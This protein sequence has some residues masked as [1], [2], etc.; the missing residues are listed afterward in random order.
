MMIARSC[1]RRQAASAKLAEP[2]STD[3]RLVARLRQAPYKT[4]MGGAQDSARDEL[5]AAVRAT[6]DS[7]SS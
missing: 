6:I 2:E 1:Q 5:K 4:S 7:T 3:A